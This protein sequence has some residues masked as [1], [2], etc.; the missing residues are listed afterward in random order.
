MI[1]DRR[2]KWPIGAVNIGI[3]S[4]A[5]SNASTLGEVPTGPAVSTPSST[6]EVRFDD[7]GLGPQLLKA[8]VDSGYTTPTPIQ[9]RGIP[10][11]LKGKDIIGIAQTGTGK[12][13]SFTL[14]MI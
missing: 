4:L 13:A 11:V 9:A 8:V 5:G 6:S 2:P 10:E 3:E 14:P 7:L 1:R 12:T